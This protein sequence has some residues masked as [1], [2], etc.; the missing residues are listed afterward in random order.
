MHSTGWA[1]AARTAF[2]PTDPFEESG[3]KGERF[4]R[5]YLENRFGKPFVKSRPEFLRHPKSGQHLELDCF[6]QELRLAVEYNGRQ[7]YEF[8]PFFHRTIDDFRAMQERDAAKSELCRRYGVSLVVVPYS[9]LSQGY[10][11]AK[12]AEIGMH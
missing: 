4:C 9:H 1:R 10:L 2:V 11:D 5:K 6:N 7:H 8:V 3:S 12:L